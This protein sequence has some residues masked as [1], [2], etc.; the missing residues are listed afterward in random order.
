M[1]S[2]ADYSSGTGATTVVGSRALPLTVLGF[3]TSCDE[4]A[5]AVVRLTEGGAQ[6]L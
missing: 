2:G 6:V 3:E 1:N 5:A 4:T